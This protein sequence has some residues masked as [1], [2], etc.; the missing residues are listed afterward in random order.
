[1]EKIQLPP[2]VSMPTMVWALL[3]GTDERR[4]LTQQQRACGARL[5]RSDTSRG[6]D[7][8][9]KRHQRVFDHF[10]AKVFVREERRRP[11]MGP[12][13]TDDDVDRLGHTVHGMH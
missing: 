1:M 7:V 4:N 6:D 9:A 13:P 8:S 2:C 11:E 12:L 10:G 3:F 5:Q